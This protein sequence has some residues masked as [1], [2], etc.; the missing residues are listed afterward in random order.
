MA[1]AARGQQP[2]GVVS[3]ALMLGD[4]SLLMM[5]VLNPGVMIIGDY[6]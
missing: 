5:I 2:I 6:C 3:L 1:G 4:D